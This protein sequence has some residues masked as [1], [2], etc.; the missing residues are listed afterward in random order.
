MDLVI[1]F[2]LLVLVAMFFR[3]FKSFI[4]ALAII[5]VFFKILT[6]IKNNIG[7]IELSNLIDKYIP[8]S[9]INV[10]G[11]Y[12]SGLFYT[13]LVWGFVACMICFLV[14]LVK[15]LFGRK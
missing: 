15:Y 13:I 6:F 8:E 9:I 14:Y 4:Y 12:S 5:E 2:I 7:I 11:R 10:L 1:I 3:K